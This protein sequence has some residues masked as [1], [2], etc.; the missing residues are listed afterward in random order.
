[1]YFQKIPNP[2]VGIMNEAD[3]T[4]RITEQ[5]RIESSDKIVVQS[6]VPE[7]K[8]TPVITLAVSLT[9]VLMLFSVRE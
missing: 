5:L 6:V 8:L 2:Y 9:V 1:M 3:L 7:P 4:Q